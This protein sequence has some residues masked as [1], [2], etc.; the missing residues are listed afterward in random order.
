[1]LAFLCLQV[2]QT[3][4]NSVEKLRTDRAPLPRRR[5]ERL[6]VERGFDLVQRLKDRLKVA[7]GGD[8]VGTELTS[9]GQAEPGA[10]AL[11]SHG[12]LI[13]VHSSHTGHSSG[14]VCS[15]PHARQPHTVC[16]TLRP[17][18]WPVIR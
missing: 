11:L 14:G 18:S 9:P 3:G 2:P 8:G 10:R 13:P 12:C 1:M 4:A 7:L 16:T 17:S 5:G 6:C 15:G